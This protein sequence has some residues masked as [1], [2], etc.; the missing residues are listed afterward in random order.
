MVECHEAKEQVVG[1]LQSQPLC[2]EQR[3]QWKVQGERKV[4]PQ[5][6]GGGK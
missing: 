4:F 3:L 6:G 1:S 5:V 2:K